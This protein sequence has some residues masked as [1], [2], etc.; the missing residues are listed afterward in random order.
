MFDRIIKVLLKYSF[1]V[2]QKNDRKY[3]FSMTHISLVI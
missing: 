2:Y 1:K 3:G